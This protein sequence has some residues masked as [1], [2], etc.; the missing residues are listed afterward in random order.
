MYHVVTF[1][2]T[3][4]LVLV[5]TQ[6]FGSSEC[7][8]VVRPVN[9]T[10]KIGSSVTLNCSTNVTNRPVNWYC[11]GVCSA[12]A[13]AV[14]LLLNGVLTER[15]RPRIGVIRKV[16]VMYVSTSLFLYF[17]ILSYCAHSLYSIQVV[18]YFTFILHGYLLSFAYISLATVSVLCYLV[19]RP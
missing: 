18:F 3:G 12:N 6:Q 19:V 15:Y 14:Y 5:I 1:R 16:A 11:M 7:A 10:A 13:S 17:Y 9:T 2:F 4:L 8:L